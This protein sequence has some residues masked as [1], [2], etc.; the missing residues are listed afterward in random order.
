MAEW[1]CE[2]MTGGRYWRHIDEGA[3]HCQLTPAIDVATVG[4]H[5][6]DLS[7]GFERFN[8]LEN[9]TLPEIQKFVQTL[10][11]LFCFVLN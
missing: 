5:L 7:I 4:L 10:G 6:L 9:N 3:K 2:V 8:Q 11:C 1:I